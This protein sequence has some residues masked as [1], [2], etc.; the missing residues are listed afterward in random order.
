MAASISHEIRNPITT[1]RGYLQLFVNKAKFVE[2][3][4]QFQTMIDELDRANS[5]ITEY[6]SLAKNKPV[7]MKRGNINTVLTTLFP[8]LQADALHAG[9]N[10]VLKT[11]TIPDT[12]FD[13]KELR[14]LVLNL[15]RNGIE[16]TPYGGIVTID[17][18]TIN[19]TVILAIQDRGTGI[20]AEALEKIGTPF[21]TTK[22]NGTGLGLAV[23]YRIAQRHKAD[24]QVETSA[25]G[26][27]FLVKFRDIDP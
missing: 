6:L 13:E 23:C 8:L 4:A 21:F 14:Q 20:T 15:V 25:G 5:I 24:I 26:T 12:Y 9:L 3:H 7:Q 22:S 17:T 11:T 27:T 19:G 10:I 16:A 2:H 1:V 18:Y